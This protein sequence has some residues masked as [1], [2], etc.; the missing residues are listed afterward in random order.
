VVTQN[1]KASY[2]KAITQPNTYSAQI[3]LTYFHNRKSL[4]R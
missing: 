2:V 3:V 1:S 4:Q